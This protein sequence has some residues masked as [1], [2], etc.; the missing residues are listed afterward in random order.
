MA[1]IGNRLN[2]FADASGL[3]TVSVFSLQSGNAQQ[4]FRDFGVNVADDMVCIGGGGTAAEGPNGAL[5]T[6]SYPNDQLSGWLVSSKDHEVPNPHQLT[7]FAIGLKI[8]GIS[9]EQMMDNFL[10]VETG[11]SGAAPHPEA[12]ASMPDPFLLVSGGFRVDWNGAGNLGTASFPENNFSWKVRS[13]DHD[14][15]DPSNIRAFAIG[16]RR[17]LPVGAVTTFVRS[18]DS[19]TSAHPRSVVALPTGFAMTGGGAEVHWSGDGNLLWMLQPATRTDRQ[20]FSS[21]SKDHIHPSPATITS[22]ILGI[23]VN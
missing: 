19:A 13:K 15:S 1:G 21:A 23:R 8:R 6:A 2:T 4:H 5:L 12:S 16:I 7:G 18:A 17:D 22:Y 3:V 20:E 10:R 11:D 14:I 9:R